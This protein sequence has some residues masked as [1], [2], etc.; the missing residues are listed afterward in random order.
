[1]EN[2]LMVGNSTQEMVPGITRLVMCDCGYAFPDGVIVK[3][4]SCIVRREEGI[5]R[6]EWEALLHKCQL[7]MNDEYWV[8]S[9]ETN[10]D[11]CM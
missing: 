3:E 5:I 8:V 10:T 6:G 11:E 4:Q 2:S 9:N 7:N 1:M